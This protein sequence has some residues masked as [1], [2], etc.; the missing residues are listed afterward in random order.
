MDAYDMLKP[1]GHFVF[2]LRKQYWVDGDE[3]GY[4]EYM[5]QLITEGKFAQ[6]KSWTHTRGSAKYEG[7]GVE[8]PKFVKMEHLIFVMKKLTA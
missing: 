8:D 6:V 1:G 3:L 7:V 5:E 2:G 4:K